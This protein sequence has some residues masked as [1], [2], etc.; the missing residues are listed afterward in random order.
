MPRQRVLSGTIWEE[1]NGYARAVRTG[2]HVYVSG[3]IAV[4][5]DGDI[6]HADSP[7][8]QTKF[9]LEK[10]ERALTQLGASRREVV[11]TRIYVT[12]IGHDQEVG[13]AH[14]DFFEDLLPCCTMVE[15]SK[16]ASRMALVE[17]EC[18][19]IIGSAPEA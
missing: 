17:V 9:C 11:R 15:V 5:D 1:R 3:T 6:V 16:L 10:I 19:A 18:E 7:H 8:L 13:K 4:D 12:N 2:D 14:L